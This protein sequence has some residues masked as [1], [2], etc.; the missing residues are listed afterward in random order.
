MPEQ[1]WYKKSRVIKAYVGIADR[2]GLCSF[3]PERDVP[4]GLMSLEAKA[5]RCRG[6]ACFWAAVD[7]QTAAHVVEEPASGR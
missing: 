1:P 2:D 7:E 5:A 6:R 3:V 4:D